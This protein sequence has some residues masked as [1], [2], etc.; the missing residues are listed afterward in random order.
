MPPVTKKV[1]QAKA[2]KE[3][4]QKVRRAEASAGNRERRQKDQDLA[5]A[6]ALAAV[7]TAAEK[8]AILHAEDLH[9][10]RLARGVANYRRHHPNPTLDPNS[11]PEEAPLQEAVPAGVLP[12]EAMPA[13]GLPRPS[14][15]PGMPHQ[16]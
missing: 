10:R 8:D 12:E 6:A 1:L 7:E 13:E 14:E 15:L 3:A 4:K 5:V 9:V 16:F 2:A 11:N